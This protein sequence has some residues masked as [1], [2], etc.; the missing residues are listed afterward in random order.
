[1]KPNFKCIE[2]NCQKD[3]WH[4]N[5]RCHSCAEKL[6]WE[7]H[8][9]LKSKDKFCK[10]CDKKISKRNKSYLCSACS[11]K[12]AYKEGRL[13]RKGKN[14][15]FFG[16]THSIGYIERLKLYM[17]GK[18]N[19]N[20]QNGISFEPYSSEFTEELK[21][22]IRG[23]DNYECQNCG[24]T[25]EEHLIVYGRILPIHH[26][27]YN[28]QNCKET[29]LITLCNQCNSRANFNRDYWKDLFTKKI[30]SQK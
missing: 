27:D 20:W 17:R 25:E 1:M 4:K 16:K 15:S 5:S 12:K 9:E 22:S 14:N 18:N 21:E 10:V 13:N 19:P 2:N 28:K 30:E 11:I 8:P 23:R 29:N 7:N 6:Y 26:I 3:V 24:M